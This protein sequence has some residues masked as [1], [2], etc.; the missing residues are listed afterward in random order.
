MK[1]LRICVFSNALSCRWGC[2]CVGILIKG[3]EV[4]AFY[5]TQGWHEKQDISRKTWSNSAR[6]LD[7]D[8]RII[9]KL[10]KYDNRVD[11]I[12]VAQDMN[13]GEGSCRCGNKLSAPVLSS[14]AIVH[15]E[16]NFQLLYVQY[17]WL[18]FEQ[19]N[20]QQPQVACAKWLGSQF[21]SDRLFSTYWSSSCSS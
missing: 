1:K 5:G 6:W 4:G 11:W 13:C 12:N 19:V 7:V 3:D 16:M 18:L 14:R 10:S 17:I 8:G 2:F 20:C 21:R 9:M 15:M